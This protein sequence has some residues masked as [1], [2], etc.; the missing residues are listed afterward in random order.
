MLYIDHIGRKEQK[1][2][3]TER[4]EIKKWLESHDSITCEASVKEEGLPEGVKKS[5]DNGYAIKGRREIA[6]RKAIYEIQL[7][8]RGKSTDKAFLLYD[9]GEVSEILLKSE[10]GVRTCNY[11][12]V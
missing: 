7:P 1:I 6:K 9:G 8:Q 11:K 5:L 2:M 12:A 3:R 10:K 4:N